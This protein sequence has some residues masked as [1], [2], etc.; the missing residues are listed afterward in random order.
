ML[1]TGRIRLSQSPYA[2]GTLLI[3]K[4]DPNAP[5]RVVHNYRALNDNTIKDHTPLPCQDDIIRAGTRGRVL[6]KMDLL[7]AYYQ[8]LM[9]E[10]DIHK[11]AF[12]TPLGLFEWV[13]MPQG[14][15]NAVA[16]FQRFMNWVLC[17]YVGRF[18]HVYINDILVWSDSIAEHHRHMRLICQ[19]LREHGVV[20]S[21]SKSIL[22]TDK[23]EFLG[24]NISYG[25]IE[26]T[27]E[28]V[29]KIIGSR[30]PCNPPEV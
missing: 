20:L 14:L 23:V 25:S 21:K 3:S 18:C 19:A 15:C 13:I 2:A 8:G 6:A 26:D 29:D 5:R 9:E 17:K 1:V 16:T 22:A 27:P 24:F 12:K 7:M 28:K 4:K 11:T 10:S 30:I